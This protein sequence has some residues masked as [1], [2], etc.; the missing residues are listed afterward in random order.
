MLEFLIPLSPLSYKAWPHNSDIERLVPEI[1]IKSVAVETLLPPMFPLYVPCCYDVFYFFSDTLF[2]REYWHVLYC[3]C[4][5]CVEFLWQREGVAKESVAKPKVIKTI[6]VMF[7]F[8]LIV[9]SY[10]ELKM[11]AVD[12]FNWTVTPE[13]RSRLVHSKLWYLNLTIQTN[14]ESLMWTGLC[15]N[16]VLSPLC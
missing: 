8:V 16:L 10:P 13:D 14:H 11:F 5:Q 12:W 3:F 15:T 2:C 6:A 1:L 9:N 7:C 4:F